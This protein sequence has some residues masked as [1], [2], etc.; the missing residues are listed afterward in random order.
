MVDLKTTDL[1][2]CRQLTVFT[3]VAS[4]SDHCVS[5]GVGERAYPSDNT[6][7]SAVRRRSKAAWASS[8]SIVRLWAF[9]MIM[10]V[11]LRERMSQRALT[12]QGQPRQ[13]FRL[14]RTHPAL[15]MGIQIERPRR[16]RYALH[17]GIINDSLKCRT[18]FAVSIVNEV[19]AK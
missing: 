14:D 2:L 3:A 18:V 8:F 19:L 1:R 15:G 11:V 4:A 10:R 12:K 9:G 6:P 17:P 13:R 5:D 16:E 7:G